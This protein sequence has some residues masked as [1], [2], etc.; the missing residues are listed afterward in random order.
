MEGET[1]REEGGKKTEKME[2]E[3]EG[4]RERVGDRPLASRK[5]LMVANMGSVSVAEHVVIFLYSL[6]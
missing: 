4:G 3:K 5:H 1:G 2:V 6:V